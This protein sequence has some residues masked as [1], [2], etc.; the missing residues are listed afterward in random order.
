M[1]RIH[2]RYEIPGQGATGNDSVDQYLV[3]AG[4]NQLVVTATN[5]TEADATAIANSVEALD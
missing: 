4:D 1:R 2:Y 5:A 3:L